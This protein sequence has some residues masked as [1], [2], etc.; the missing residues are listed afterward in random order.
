[1]NFSAAE[2]KAIRECGRPRRYK[3]DRKRIIRLWEGGWETQQGIADI[4]HCSIGSVRKVL[5]DAGFQE[6]YSVCG[7]TWKVIKRERT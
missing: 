5:V 1:M 7:E 3:I 2:K 6:E 4:C